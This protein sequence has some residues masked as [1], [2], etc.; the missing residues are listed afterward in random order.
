MQDNIVAIYLTQNNKVFQIWFIFSTDLVLCF[1]VFDSSDE[2][3]Y[4]LEIIFLASS[5]YIKHIWQI[6]AIIFISWKIYWE[7]LLNIFP[8]NSSYTVFK[9]CCFFLYHYHTSLF[10]S[11]LGKLHLDSSLKSLDLFLCSIY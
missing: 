1:I 5:Y 9:Y 6:W 3:Y 8:K 10:S 4:R 11:F 7:I 2:W